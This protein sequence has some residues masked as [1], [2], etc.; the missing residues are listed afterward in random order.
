MLITPTLVPEYLN[1]AILKEILCKSVKAFS[2][3]TPM[4]CLI[5]CLSRKSVYTDVTN[6]VISMGH[7]KPFSLFQCSPTNTKLAYQYLG[8]QVL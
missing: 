6:A 2:T 5:Y 7:T 1:P 8:C 4:V 3:E